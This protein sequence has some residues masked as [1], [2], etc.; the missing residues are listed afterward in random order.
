MV[1]HKFSRGKGVDVNQRKM[2][3]KNSQYH[4]NYYQASD[5]SYGFERPISEDGSSYQASVKHSKDGSYYNEKIYLKFDRLDYHP[6][7]T[8]GRYEIF[9]QKDNKINRLANQKITLLFGIHI[10][11]GIA[12]VTLRESLKSKLDYYNHDMI[13][14]ESTPTI[15]MEIHNNS[16]NDVIVKKGESLCFVN[17]LTS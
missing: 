10:E 12:L 14:S 5:I 13:I 4:G 6:I 17:L 3:R 7:K 1:F 9:A 2:F 15:T 16:K 8:I 11:S